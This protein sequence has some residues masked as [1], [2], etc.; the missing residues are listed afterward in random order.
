[1]GMMAIHPIP[2]GTLYTVTMATALTVWAT[3]STEMTVSQV[4]AWATR[5]M[6]MMVLVRIA[7]V[8]PSTEIGRTGTDVDRAIDS[9]MDSRRSIW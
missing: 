4:I 9:R 6:E 3:Q 7:W 2:W 5:S 8:T 1:M